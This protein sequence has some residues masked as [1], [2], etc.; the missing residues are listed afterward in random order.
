MKYRVLGKTGLEISI[1]GYGSS[2]LSGQYGPISDMEAIRSV[3]MA[4]DHG[5]NLIDSG[6]ASIA[7]QAEVLLSKALRNIPR[8][9][10][11]L[12]ARVGSRRPMPNAGNFSKSTVL[13]SVDQS[14]KR[15]QLD[16]IDLVQ[17]HGMEYADT[18]QIVEE[19]VPTLRHAQTAGKVRF[20]GLSGPDLKLLTC[21]AKEVEV[22]QVQ[23][24]CHHYFSDDVL[25]NLAADLKESNLGVLNA[26]PLA[27]GLMTEAGPARWHPSSPA[28]HQLCAEVARCCRLHGTNISKLA[29]QFAVSEPSIHTTIIG[30][31]DPS[32]I[33]ENIRNTEKSLNFELLA[34]VR[35]ILSPIQ[36]LYLDSQLGDS[37]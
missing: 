12:V 19:T 17:V 34:M 4:L 1:L 16:H 11:V 3:H 10:Y 27:M 28:I 26:A 29:V 36:S 23:S 2:S 5:L 25:S 37:N 18:R 20:V 8:D 14:L 15:L 33:V 32:H 22:D 31:A 35:E 30:S 6:P 9:Q 24:C 21:V 13:K 7:N